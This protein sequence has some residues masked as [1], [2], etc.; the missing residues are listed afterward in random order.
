[1]SKTPFS[2]KC[3]VLAGLWLYYRD[4]AQKNSDW[5]DFFRY[6]DV[7][8]PLSYVLAENLVD[9]ATEDGT[10]IIEETWQMFCEYINIDPDGEYASIVDAFDASEQPPL[11]D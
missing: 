9:A 4:E 3:D 10:Q 2:S 8:L 5:V 7:G 6:N 11:N 1:M